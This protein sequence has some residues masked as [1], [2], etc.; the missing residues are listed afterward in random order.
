MCHVRNKSDKRETMKEI[1]RPNKETLRMFE[2]KEN[3]EKFGILEV[4]TIK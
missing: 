1:E 4:D 2:E 3:Y